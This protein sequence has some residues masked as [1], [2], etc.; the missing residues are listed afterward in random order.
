MKIITRCHECL[1]NLSVDTSYFS[2]SHMKIYECA[3]G[4]CRIWYNT[5]T[6]QIDSYLVWFNKNNKR[7]QVAASRNDFTQFYIQT[8]YNT[9]QTL[10]LVHQYKELYIKD[11]VVQGNELF[12]KML[13]LLTFS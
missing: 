4:H 8:E 13:V 9:L 11:N 6:R 3:W 7:Y 5:T 2:S 1:G 10:L 12:E